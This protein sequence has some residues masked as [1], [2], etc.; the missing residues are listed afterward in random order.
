ME[1]Q[2]RERG[3]NKSRSRT[4]NSNNSSFSLQSKIPNTRCIHSYP[5]LRLP[6]LSIPLPRPITLKPFT[7]S[8][9]EQTPRHSAVSHLHARRPKVKAMLR[10]P[11]HHAKQLPPPRTL[12]TLWR[13][14]RQFNP[15][16]SKRFC[17]SG[18]ESAPGVE[19]AVGPV[20]V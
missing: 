2:W 11:Q 17:G 8:S 12:P 20:S 15:L 3:E 14:S 4:R 10:I 1:S 6:S 5:H 9:V 18:G 7:Q 19:F 16:W 13:L